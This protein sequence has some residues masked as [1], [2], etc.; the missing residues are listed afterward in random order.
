VSS[1]NANSVAA[2]RTAATSVSRRGA[3]R[4]E[5]LDAT[6]TADDGDPPWSV[7]KFATHHGRVELA[8]KRA[9]RLDRDSM[10]DSAFY[11]CQVRHNSDIDGQKH[12]R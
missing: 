12:R 8:E 9:D 7:G 1:E 5:K 3:D 6:G 10:L 4:Q 11:I 2:E